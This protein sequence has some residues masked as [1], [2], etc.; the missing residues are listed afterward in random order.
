MQM[1]KMVLEELVMRLE[2]EKRLEMNVFNLSG[3]KK[4]K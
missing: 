2:K 1:K 3:K 4:D